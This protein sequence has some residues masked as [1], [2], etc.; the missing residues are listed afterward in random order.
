VARSEREQIEGLRQAIEWA[1]KHH[2]LPRCK[3]GNCLRDHGMELLEPSC[4]C[5]AFN[6][7][8]DFRKDAPTNGLYCVR[9]QKPI[10]DA[11]KAVRV[12]VDWNTWLATEGGE[13]FMG[14]DCWKTISGRNRHT[15]GK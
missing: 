11:S 15:E 1:E 3:H 14:A 5:R 8:P 4:G 13:E 2:P 10:K 7:D 12:T 6:L 9:C